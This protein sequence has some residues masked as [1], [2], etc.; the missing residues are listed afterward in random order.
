M[1]ITINNNL[2]I[3]YPFYYIEYKYKLNDDDKQIRIYNY[4]IHKIIELN[5]IKI[6]NIHKTYNIKIICVNNCLKNN[7][8]HENYYEIEKCYFSKEDA[9]IEAKKHLNEIK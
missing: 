4:I 9:E 6:V 8:W 5:Y 7:D 3:G 1:N 2:Q